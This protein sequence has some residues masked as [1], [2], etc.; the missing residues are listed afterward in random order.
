MTDVFTEQPGVLSMMYVEDGAR[1][2]ED[3]KICD[4]ELMKAMF[5]LAAPC[6]GVVR[7][8]FAL[9]ESVAAGDVIAVIDKE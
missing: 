1:V 7:F 2:D 5:P 8:R 3:T 4:I 9:G 6:S